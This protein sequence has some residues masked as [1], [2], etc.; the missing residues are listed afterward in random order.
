MSIAVS[1]NS[2]SNQSCSG[3]PNP[4]K[5]GVIHARGQLG[6]KTVV[7]KQRVTSFHAYRTGRVKFSN[8]EFGE[9]LV[10]GYPKP[11][12]EQPTSSANPA[13]SPEVSATKPEQVWDEG[14]QKYKV[15]N[16][17]EW[18]LQ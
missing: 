5:E 2:D 8:N 12:A 18:I 13:Q 16:G 3:N 11:D 15:W 9:V 14:I 1:D 10:E 6:D 17:K 7:G 4:S